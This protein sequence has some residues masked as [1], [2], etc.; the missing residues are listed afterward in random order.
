MRKITN[1]ELR[2]IIREE[3]VNAKATLDEGILEKIFSKLFGKKIEK[4]AKD[5]GISRDK[6]AQHEKELSDLLAKYIDVSK[7]K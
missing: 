1:E 2:E 3:I 5:A 6:L 4:I 7:T